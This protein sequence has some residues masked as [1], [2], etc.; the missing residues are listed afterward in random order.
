MAT[1]S[2]QVKKIAQDYVNYA[3]QKL[4]VERALLFGSAARDEAD[5]NSDIDLIIISEDFKK[6]P[7]TGRLVFLSKLRGRNFIDWPMDILGY[8]AEEFEKL[9]QVSSMFAEAKR[10]GIIIN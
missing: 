8:T 4:D 6:M 3:K 1:I 7:L 9:S 2:N 5:Q 10:D